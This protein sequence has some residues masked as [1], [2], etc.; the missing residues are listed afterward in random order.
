MGIA[1]ILFIATL[2]IP[3][4][5]AYDKARKDKIMATTA[6]AK[7]LAESGYHQRNAIIAWIFVWLFLGVLVV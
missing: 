7:K 2:P 5:V 6:K 3:L 4:A 1:I